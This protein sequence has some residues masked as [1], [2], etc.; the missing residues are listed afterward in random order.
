MDS[1]IINIQQKRIECLLCH[2]SAE[3]ADTIESLQQMKAQ[4]CVIKNKLVQ[5]QKD[6]EELYLTLTEPNL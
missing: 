1:G 6:L 4:E 5:S 3:I 2:I